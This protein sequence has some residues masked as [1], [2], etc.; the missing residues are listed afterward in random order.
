[1][2]WSKFFNFYGLIFAALISLNY[3]FMSLL[4]GIPGNVVALV[5][6]S[7]IVILMALFATFWR[8]WKVIPKKEL[9]LIMIAGVLNFGFYTYAFA[10]GI[11]RT[12]ATQASII[13]NVS[14]I[15]SM[16]FSVIFKLER[17]SWSA[18]L[19]AAVAIIG[20]G[21]A[22]FGGVQHGSGSIY[23]DL[24]VLVA[25]I[26]YSFSSALVADI[27]KKYHPTM[28]TSVL[29]FFGLL[30]LIP[31][32]FVDVQQIHWANLGEVNYLMLVFSGAL[33][34]AAVFG[35]Y[36][37]CIAQVGASSAS[38]YSFF[39]IP[40]TALLSF[41]FLHQGIHL[42]Q[43]V[44]LVIVF[45]GAGWCIYKRTQKNESISHTACH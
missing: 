6:V 3:L 27:N 19:G 13:F 32:S 12:S 34:G 21:I 16:V 41:I 2:K 5:R 31:I 45:A 35:V 18:F 33:G 4:K 1:M 37:K 30:I 44:G 38:A 28:F 20:V 24:L 9:L 42:L 15:F 23:G 14:P 8:K 25:A 26:L 17:W 36:Y 29:S 10:E 22:S 11:Q 43:V 7:F 39:S 40:L